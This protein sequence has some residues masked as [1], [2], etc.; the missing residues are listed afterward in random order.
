[1]WRIILHHII[2]Q[3]NKGNILHWKNTWK[4]DMGMTAITDLVSFFLAWNDVTLDGGNFSQQTGE[5]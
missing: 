2:V 4:D 5:A 3:Q 1:M